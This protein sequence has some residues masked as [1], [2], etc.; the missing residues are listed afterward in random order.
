MDNRLFKKKLISVD[1]TPTHEKLEKNQSL[2]VFY[3]PK[4]PNQHFVP[5][6]CEY[7]N[8]LFDKYQHMRHM[9]IDI[10]M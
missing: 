4:N 5:L 3:N 9:P 10:A 8:E 1:K 7:D 2:V 6:L